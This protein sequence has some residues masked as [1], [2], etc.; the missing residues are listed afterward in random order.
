M[1]L[2]DQQERTHQSE[3]AR[4]TYNAAT[5]VG[6]GYTTNVLDVP[7]SGTNIVVATNFVTVK[8]LNLTGLTNVQ[9]QMVTVDTVWPFTS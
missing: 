3:P 9:V 5:R 4:W 6:T 8:M 2:L 1:G 7:V